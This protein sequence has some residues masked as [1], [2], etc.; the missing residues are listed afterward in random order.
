MIQLLFPYGL[1]KSSLESRRSALLP[2][3]LFTLAAA[4]NSKEHLFD[5]N[6][7]SELKS[8]GVPHFFPGEEFFPKETSFREKLAAGPPLP[9]SFMA[10]PGSGSSR[11]SAAVGLCRLEDRSIDFKNYLISCKNM[12]Q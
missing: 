7:Y 8:K 10:A 6:N 5:D 3:G 2:G 12:V 1:G 11:E 4:Y 9:G